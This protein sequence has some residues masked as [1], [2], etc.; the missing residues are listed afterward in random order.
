VVFFTYGVDAHVAHPKPFSA[1][2]K[3]SAAVLDCYGAS[4]SATIPESSQE[5][6]ES[7]LQ[8]EAADTTLRTQL[9][10][11]HSTTQPHKRICGL[12]ES[13]L[14][15]PVTGVSN[16]GGMLARAHAHL[17]PGLKQPAR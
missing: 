9:P 6:E 15:G 8:Q 14:D 12:P 13:A 7:A 16:Y 11:Q 2:R 17:S 3:R 5:H 4:V 1:K 10:M